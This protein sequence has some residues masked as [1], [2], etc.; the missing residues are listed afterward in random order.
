[1]IKRQNKNQSFSSKRRG[2]KIAEDLRK[3]KRKGTSNEG[4]D[5]RFVIF[6]SRNGE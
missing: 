4:L 5:R 2:K 3:K 6:Y 1:L